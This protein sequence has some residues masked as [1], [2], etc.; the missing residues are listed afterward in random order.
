MK[1]KVLIVGLGGIG[2]RHFQAVLKCKS[3]IDLYVVDISIEAIER[4]K[5]YMTEIGSDI[6]VFFYDNINNIYNEI[7][8]VTI[9][10]TASKNRRTIFE[11]ILGNENTLYN[12]IFEKV[13]F[14]DLNDY[15]K[16]KEIIQNNG[17]HAYVNCTGREN[18]DYQKLREHI[19]NAKYY[20]FS[21]RGSNWGLA[22]NSIHKIDMIAFLTNYTGTDM[23]LDGSLLES[24]I[25]ESK[26]PGYNEFY[27]IFSGKMGDNIF[28]VFE[29]SHDNSPCIFD[30]YT[31][32]GFYSIREGD[33]I[34][35]NDGVNFKSEFFE[36]EYVS[37]IS[38]LVVDNLLNN[39]SVYLPSFEES[40]KY[41][42]PMLEMFIKTQNEITGEISNI[43]NIT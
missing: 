39:R 32:E 8:D 28:F 12:V 22:C 1:K 24:K 25:Y 14:N 9:I 11:S 3:D 19:R 26:R 16:V 35:I 36:L 29:C 18:K 41:H 21:L 33:K 40:I 37:N 23:Q 31:D 27:G 7:F 38:T 4:A 13:L 34:I 43:C 6:N 15:D 42:I 17:I 30:I 5:T 2:Y 10:A 20:R